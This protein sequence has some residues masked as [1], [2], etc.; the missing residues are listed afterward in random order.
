MSP[1]AV[2]SQQYF[3]VLYHCW[4]SNRLSTL[5]FF[6]SIKILFLELVVYIGYE[7]GEHDIY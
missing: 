5:Q 2:G 1:I 3:G 6:A 7:N 4:P